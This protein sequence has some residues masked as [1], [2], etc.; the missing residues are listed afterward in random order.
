[1]DNEIET[2]EEYTNSEFAKDIAKAVAVAAAP[3]VTYV[4]G[5]FIYRKVK[6][7]KAKKEAEKT[8]EN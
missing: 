3:Y 7:F 1:M 5:K 4:A 6:E 8:E 2:T